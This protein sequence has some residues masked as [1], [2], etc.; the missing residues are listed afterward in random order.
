M[1]KEK[2][3]L[4][5]RTIFSVCVCV[6]VCDGYDMCVCVCVCDG[7][8]V[9]VMGMMCVCVCVCVCVLWFRVKID[10]FSSFSLWC[11]SLCV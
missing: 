8:D 6:C 1:E 7:Y 9:C 10:C 3:T 11:C 2:Q 5:K 4:W